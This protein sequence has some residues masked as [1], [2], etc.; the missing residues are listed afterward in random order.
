MNPA[1]F[2]SPPASACTLGAE[3]G[4]GPDRIT[5]NVYDAAGQVLQEQ[6]AYGTPLQQNYASY[7]Y[8]LNGNRTS[9]TDA[10]G[11]RAELRYDGHDRQVRWVFPHPTTTGAVNEGD[12]E[13]Y[14]YDAGGNRT[15]LR[16]RD[17]V[18]ITYSYDQLG[19]LL[20]KTVPASATGAA[21]YSVHY[22]YD[23]GNRQTFA[24]FGSASGTG[25]TNVYDSF[26]RVAS[27]TNNMGALSRVLS[28]QYDAGSSRS[29]LTFPDGHFLAYEYD[30]GARLTAIRENGGTAVVTFT[31]DAAA[32]LSGRASTGASASYGYDAI[33]RLASL[34]TDLAGTASDQSLGLT[35][36][37]ASQIVTRT[38]SNDA[39]ASNT[40]YPV[41][42]SYSVNGLN[43]YI[44][45]G[46]ATFLYDANGNLRADGSTSFVY[47]AENRLVS[48]SGGAN[49]TLSYD[50]LGR[51]FQTTGAGGT[52]QL[53]YDGDELVAEYSNSGTMFR[54][55][56]HGTGSDNPVLWYE[57][58]S[59]TQRRSLFTDH[60]GSIVAV[61]DGT[62]NALAINGYDA[63]GIPN[64]ANLGRFG[65]TGQGWLPELGMWYYKARIYSPTLGRFLQTDPVG[66]EGGVNLY[67][68]VEN[69][70]VNLSDST[71]NKP[72]YVMDRVLGIP[73]PR[74]ES[75]TSSFCRRF[76]EVLGD[77]IRGATSYPRDVVRAAIFAAERAGLRG[78]A[79][80]NRARL[81]QDIAA[82]AAR[83]AEA[84]PAQVAR[85]GAELASNN[86]TFLAARIITGGITTGAIGGLPGVGI[87]ATALLGG[88]IGQLNR[89]V[90]QLES[91]NVST[92]RITGEGASNIMAAGALGARVNFDSATGNVNA[93]FWRPETGS[94]IPR[95]T[96][97]TLCNVNS[98]RGC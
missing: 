68:Y 96:T 22:G 38:A 87:S 98:A 95:V 57:G 50:P 43:Q 21:G 49:A 34:G 69:D 12:Y 33:S 19:R 79:A 32:R 97:V 76:S 78:E 48:A 14:G 11:N 26:G 80:Q 77:V 40:A 62:G 5:R 41:N 92:S 35:R 82:R 39:Y 51:L 42:R 91:G 7:G 4:H 31:Y 1:A 66:Y 53:L 61:A 27:T 90:D 55:Y 3:G 24:R 94:N 56:A 54:R 9:V 89:V 29:R 45:A 67:E 25:I 16:K 47:D 70:P 65:Y 20:V 86:R 46:P 44:A 28:Y 18:T 75:C 84:N 10:N 58:E 6:R 13:A 71:G 17:G 81:V 23:V 83:Y 64:S 63:W 73:S 72:D 30:A 59:L 36:N 2:A 88:G 37:A 60:Q 15:S 52:T 93:S 85:I 74:Q 8:S